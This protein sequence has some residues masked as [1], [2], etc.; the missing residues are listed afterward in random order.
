MPLPREIREELELKHAQ[1]EEQAA[2]D[3][4][5]AKVRMALG[6][7][8]SSML[9]LVCMGW[10]FHTT[11]EA[12]GRILLSTGVIVG[13]A[14]VAVTLLGGYVRGKDKGYW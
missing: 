1:Q 10:A 14:G 7:I 3:S 5:W 2:R 12:L 4:M 13:Y 11:D 8:A 9:G 6:C